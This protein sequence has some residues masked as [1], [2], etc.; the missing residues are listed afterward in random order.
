M[1][2]KTQLF[3]PLH[4]A[5]AHAEQNMLMIWLLLAGPDLPIEALAKDM[6]GCNESLD[7]GGDA[8][9]AGAEEGN[10]EEEDVDWG[11]DSDDAKAEDSFDKIEGDVPRL[12]RGATWR[13]YADE[14]VAETTLQGLAH[15]R[16]KDIYPQDWMYSDDEQ[17]LE[18]VVKKCPGLPLPPY[19]SALSLRR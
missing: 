3:T 2:T 15:L 13:E 7:D 12:R 17:L 9:D 1:Q 4:I 19:I 5:S 11:S 16:L 18:L 14:N 8:E 10:L 6:G